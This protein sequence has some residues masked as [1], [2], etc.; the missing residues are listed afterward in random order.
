MY[1]ARE[2]GIDGEDARPRA[3]ENTQLPTLDSQHL[4]AL[5]CDARLANDP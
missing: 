3:G 5:K 2:G 1:E 4:T